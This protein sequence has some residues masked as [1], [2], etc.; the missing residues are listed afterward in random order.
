MG[1][2]WNFC[3]R[4]HSGLYT[5]Q[6]PSYLGSI[7]LSSIWNLENGIDPNNHSGI[8]RFCYLDIPTKYLYFTDITILIPT[9]RFFDTMHSPILY[10]RPTLVITNL[11]LRNSSA[12]TLDQYIGEDDLDLDLDIPVKYMS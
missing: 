1:N 7:V 8:Q 2:Q 11:G 3:F 12:H 6:E 9:G 4:L 5:M 10:T